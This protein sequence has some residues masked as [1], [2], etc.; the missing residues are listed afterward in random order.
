MKTGLTIDL[1]LGHTAR[2]HVLMHVLNIA[3]FGLM[4]DVSRLDVQTPK[5]VWR[6][7][8]VEALWLGTS[9]CTTTPMIISH[10]LWLIDVY[11]ANPMLC[12]PTN[13]NYKDLNQKCDTWKA[14][15]AELNVDRLK[16]MKKIDTQTG[17]CRQ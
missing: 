12:D 2:K 13:P 16:V 6:R 17:Q 15:G 3:W 10:V 7:C 5:H 11:R 8:C 9:V 1:G 4:F 14:I